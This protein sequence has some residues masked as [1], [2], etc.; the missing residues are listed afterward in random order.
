MLIVVVD[1]PAKV[2]TSVFATLN[3]PC[4]GDSGEWKKRLAFMLDIEVIVFTPAAVDQID[5][6]D[7]S[8]GL[9]TAASAFVHDHAGF[10]SVIFGEPNIRLC[11]VGAD[12]RRRSNQNGCPSH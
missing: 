8:E 5:G 9:R 10:G 6:I 11:E 4:V 12:E 1:N 7:R 2:V 3:G